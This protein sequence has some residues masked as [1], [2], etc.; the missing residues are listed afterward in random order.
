MLGKYLF[1]LALALAAAADSSPF[2]LVTHFVQEPLALDEINYISYDT[3]SSD[4]AGVY[5][6]GSSYDIQGTVTNDGYLQ[7]VL[8]GYVSNDTFLYVDETNG[9]V[10]VS[11]TSR[12]G[13]FEIHDEVLY[14]QGSASFY[15]TEVIPSEGYDLYW[16][17]N[18]SGVISTF[19]VLLN[20]TSADGDDINDFTPSSATT[21]YA[22]TTTTSV[23]PTS[24]LTAASGSG[25]TLNQNLG[26]VLLASMFSL[27]SSIW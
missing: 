15:L 1:S 23:A 4:T 16:G 6:G 22:L 2:R 26:L 9:A 21:T 3:T 25:S 24:S 17:V 8:G 10:S 14:Y 18:D 13:P 27:F 7:I 20:T 5:T 12:S 11:N 19:T